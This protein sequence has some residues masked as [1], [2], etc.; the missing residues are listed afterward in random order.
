MENSLTQVFW[1]EIRIWIIPPSFGKREEKGESH[2]PKKHHDKEDRD[3][4]C[5]GSPGAQPEM[6]Y[7]PPDVVLTRL[8]RGPHGMMVQVRPLET[9]GWHWTCPSQPRAAGA[10]KFWKLPKADFFRLPAW[11]EHF[12][13]QLDIGPATGRLTADSLC[14]DSTQ[15]RKHMQIFK[16]KNNTVCLAK[17]CKS[18]WSKHRLGRE[19]KPGSN[20]QVCQAS[21]V[22]LHAEG[23]PA[24]DV[25]E[26]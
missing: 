2:H 20:T 26:F 18:W 17:L 15:S 22:W 10:Q 4:C 9:R 25:A 6:I 7:F 14:G 3:S 23:R 13:R 21:P 24:Y 8:C 16:K 12:T 5:Q 11:H 1:R 19:W